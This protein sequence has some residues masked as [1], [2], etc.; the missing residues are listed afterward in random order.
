MNTRNFLK[1]IGSALVLG[2]L[3]LSSHA[4]DLYPGLINP[5]HVVSKRLKPG[6]SR[7]YDYVLEA[8]VLTAHDRVATTVDGRGASP[9]LQAPSTYRVNYTAAPGAVW[10]FKVYRGST[11]IAERNVSLP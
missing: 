4:A 7:F 1:S 8:K 5:M 10:Q 9:Y 11:R 6:S 2:A 3:A